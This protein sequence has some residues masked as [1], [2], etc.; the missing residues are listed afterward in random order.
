MSKDAI[1]TARTRSQ[2]G[3]TLV[4]LMVTVSVVSIVIGAAYSIFASSSASMYEVDSLSNTTDKAR[5]DLEVISRDIQAA[6]AN[7]THDSSRDTL[8]HPTQRTALPIYGVYAFTANQQLQR[9]PM[10]S[11]FNAATFSDEII[12]VGSYDYPFDFEVTFDAGFTQA[13]APNTIRGA[14]RF[15]HLD[16]FDQREP[17][18]YGGPQLTGNL[19]TRIEDA[20]SMNGRV[21]RVYDREGISQFIDIT[22]V[23]YTPGPG[24]N[25]GL[26]MNLGNGTALRALE[27]QGQQSYG[28]EPA[29][30]DDEAYEAA[31]IDA[32]RYRTCIDPFDPQNLRIVKERIDASTLMQ[33]TAPP[34]PDM[35][36]VQVGTGTGII[37]QEP[38]VDRVVDF[39]IWYDCAAP[40]TGLLQNVGWSN[41][42]IP[43]NPTDAG[44]GG[45]DCMYLNSSGGTAGTSSPGLGRMAHVRLS[46]RTNAER[47]TMTNYGFVTVNDATINSING[48][49]ASEA[50]ESNVT[51]PSIGNLGNVQTLAGLQTFDIDGDATN[52]ARVVTLQID[53][54]MA[55]FAH[56]ERLQNPQ[57]ISGGP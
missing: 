48:P 4:E 2:A 35:C 41:G 16:P 17:T 22:G 38:L 53:V 13:I 6:G 44:A 54:N 49:D 12:V 20:D 33:G 15:V 39:R 19:L 8:V 18:D 7:A 43:P 11:E 10:Q 40:G 52:A 1:P 31:L 42:W 28:L 45:H 29:A 56:R 5:F 34:S 37:S 21:L 23:A 30:E 14:L 3:F 47:Q 26:T 57:G 24:S 25:N 9:D 36:G 32:Y 27:K 55:N 50:T 46:V 51:P